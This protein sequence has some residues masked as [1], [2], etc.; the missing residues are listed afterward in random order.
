[1]GKY[2]SQHYVGTKNPLFVERIKQECRVC[3]KPY[4]VTPYYLTVKKYCSYKCKHIAQSD[5]MSGE[6][7]PFWKGGIGEKYQRWGKGFGKHLKTL[8]KKRDKFICQMCK[9]IESKSDLRFIVHHIDKNPQNNE[10]SNLILLCHP[11]HMSI[12][13]KHKL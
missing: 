4:F 7:N 9:M 11:C 10:I 13:G 12:H 3:G 8:V 6:G 5:R 1:M 2:R